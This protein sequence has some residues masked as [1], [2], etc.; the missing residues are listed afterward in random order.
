MSKKTYH[1]LERLREEVGFAEERY[2]RSHG[3]EHTSD[4]P[5][6]LWLWKK[7][8]P[9][10]ETLLVETGT[11]ISMQAHSCAIRGNEW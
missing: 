2:L 8:T 1:E 5:G 7:T 10:G 4:T 9:N 11:A 6:C 3:W